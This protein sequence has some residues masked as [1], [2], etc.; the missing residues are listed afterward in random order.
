MNEI[1]LKLLVAASNS[2]IRI[3]DVLIEHDGKVWGFDGTKPVAVEGLG[4][5]VL[6][7]PNGPLDSADWTRMQHL[8][9]RYTCTKC[10]ETRLL[11]PDIAEGKTVCDRCSKKGEK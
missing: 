7:D 3:N 8:T 2:Q 6:F 1:L 10:G 4:D 11:E 5:R 9:N